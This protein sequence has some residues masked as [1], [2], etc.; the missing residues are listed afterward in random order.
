ML[1]SGGGTGA[2][3]DRVILIGGVR[4]VTSMAQM[5]ASFWHWFVIFHEDSWRWL[6]SVGSGVCF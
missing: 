4:F 1:P 5:P 2:G 3:P 6:V